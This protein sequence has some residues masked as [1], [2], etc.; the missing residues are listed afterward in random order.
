[1]ANINPKSK[2]TST[3][4][5]FAHRE[6]ATKLNHADNTILTNKQIIKFI[7]SICKASYCFNR[8][9]RLYESR[10]DNQADDKSGVLETLDCACK[11]SES[12]RLALRRSTVANDTMKTSKSAIS[13]S[14]MNLQVCSTDS[15]IVIINV[16]Y[17]LNMN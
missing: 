7:Y 8:F 3:E 16:C 11:Q 12:S 10:S 17:N 15:N 6:I 9:L 14:L 4:T 13:C 5:S 1:M 2:T